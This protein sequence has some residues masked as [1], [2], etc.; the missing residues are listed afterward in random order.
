VLRT[1]VRET[2]RVARFGG[3]EFVVLLPD[4]ALVDAR[5]LA[6]RLR[7]QVAS[8]PLVQPNLKLSLTVSIG[9]AEWRPGSDDATR[10]MM[11]ADAALY[12]A[13][14]GGR[15]RVELAR[16]APAPVARPASLTS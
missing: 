16:E 8:Q 14:Q 10:L 3:E 12:R 2:D 6:E 7:E 1:G 15:D 5:P 11:R 9:V 4:T 13:K